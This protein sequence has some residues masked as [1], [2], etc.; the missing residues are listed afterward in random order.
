MR[1]ASFPQLI[2]IAT[3]QT[4]ER[5]RRR[6]EQL[7]CAGLGEPGSFYAARE[8]FGAFPSRVFVLGRYHAVD[9]LSEGGVAEG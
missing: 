1:A 5:R 2:T 8:C 4:G 9:Q 7:E 3:P 6:A